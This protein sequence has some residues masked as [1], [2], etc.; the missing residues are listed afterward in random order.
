M[1]SHSGFPDDYFEW[2]EEH[3]RKLREQGDTT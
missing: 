3:Y 2:F 1:L